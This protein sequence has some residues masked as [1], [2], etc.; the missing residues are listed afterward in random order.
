MGGDKWSLLSVRVIWGVERRRVWAT[1]LVPMH[2]RFKKEKTC[3]DPKSRP[4]SVAESPRTE[5]E[6]ASPT[7][8]M[9]ARKKSVCLFLFS[10][11]D[12]RGKD[13]CY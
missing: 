1:R 4:A 8:N 13:G 3:T 5:R 10:D 11:H 9:A 6:E 12:V 2:T 7:V